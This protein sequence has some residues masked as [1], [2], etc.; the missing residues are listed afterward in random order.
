MSDEYTRV[1]KRIAGLQEW[2][3]E[4]Q[5]RLTAH[6]AISPDSGGEG[7]VA[8]A[9]ALEE[10][11]K[12]IGAEQI[13]HFDAPDERAKGGK[14]PNL[15]VT[16]PGRGAPGRLWIMSHLDVVSEGDRD[17][18]DS[19]PWKVRIDGDKL[20]G[21]GVED[22]QQGIVASLLLARALLEE[23]VV[24]QR[25]ICLLFVADE[26]VGS[27]FGIQYLLR[28]K[29]D[30]FHESDWIIVPDGGRPDGTQNEV[31]EKSII[32][33]RFTVRGKSTHASTPERGINAHR[34]ASHLVVALEGL[35]ETF[36][37]VD[38]V[39]DPP[40]C[41]F[42]PTKRDANVGSVNIVPGEDIFW[43][44][45]RV[46]PNY[47][48]KDVEEEVSRHCRTIEEKFD[49]KVE[50]E[51]PQREEAAP[52]TASDAP[53]V[54]ALQEA[55]RDVYDVEAKPE[56]IGGGTVAAYIRRSGV[57]AVVW[58]TMDE[59]MHTANEYVKLSNIVGDAK[60]FT[61]LAL[62]ES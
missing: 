15:I 40:G 10:I 57:P 34:A 14:R 53:V 2:A 3:I 7:E 31:A 39:F 19:D 29:E 44:D 38:P 55:V 32:W 41:T 27:K 51:A 42:E 22:N 1:A 21:R 5:E 25:E 43:L 24:P 26:E 6:P 50:W 35:H 56:G 17:K 60:V 13:E 52:P 45:C 46:L 59:T 36:S 61:K 23:K 11:L 47:P 18:W 33:V 12:E 9:Q 62:K 48:L 4:V 30:L 8:K 16:I 49:V 58:A 20:Y 37:D 28:E 54:L